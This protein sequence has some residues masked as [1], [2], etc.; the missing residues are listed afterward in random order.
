MRLAV[1]EGLVEDMKKTDYY[2]L[3]SK[4][5]DYLDAHRKEIEGQDE[6]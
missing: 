2:R 1:D 3:T 5:H 6:S 4:G